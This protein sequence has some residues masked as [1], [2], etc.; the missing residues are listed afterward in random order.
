MVV[1]VGVSRG[2]LSGSVGGMGGKG[3]KGI[4]GTHR[5]RIGSWNIG[6][7]MGKSIELAKILQKRRVSIACVQETRWVGLKARNVDEFKLWYSWV[8]RGKNGVGI[9]VDRDLRESVVEFRRVNDS[10]YAPQ[11]GLDEEVKRRFWEGLDELVSSI[12]HSEKLVVRGDFNGHIGAAAGGYGEVHGGFGLG[13]RN[14]GGT[15][16]LDFATAFE[17]LIAN[18]SFP[19]RE[20]HLVTFK[21]SA[22][23]TQIDYLL[24]RRSD[25]GVVPI[26]YLCGPNVVEERNNTINNPSRAI[27]EDGPNSING[28]Q[29][30]EEP[31]LEEFETV[32]GGEGAA[33]GG[34]DFSGNVEEE[35]DSVENLNGGEGA[36]EEEVALEVASSES[37]LD[38]LLEENDRS[39]EEF[40]DCSDTGSDDTDEEVE[41]DF[42]PG[43]GLPSRRKSTNVRYNTECEVA[44]FDL[45]MI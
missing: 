6:T 31:P 21:S 39:D 26:G 19:K 23:R 11:A 45:G 12:P 10:A 34:E 37:D 1:V 16:L 25:R 7:L 18:S 40:I 17:L 8:V 41:L 27:I 9:L 38:E 2:A 24:L 44:I 32:I 30:V 28:P 3:G 20:E 5:L 13:V 15:S 29:P 33:S 43:V 36:D 22:A 4:T 42:Q 14:G 35:V